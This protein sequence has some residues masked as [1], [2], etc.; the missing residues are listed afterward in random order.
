[1]RQ[2]LAA[3]ARS[4]GLISTWRSFPASAKVAG[5][6][7]GPT[8]GAVPKAGGAPG[9]G[10]WDGG[11]WGVWAGRMAVSRTDEPSKPRELRE[12]IERNVRRDVGMMVLIQSGEWIGTI[13]IWLE[14][15]KGEI[16]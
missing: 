14:A 10:D 3:V 2:L 8:G 12:V 13:L 9:V 1:M 7:S 15:G 16:A 4:A 5:V 6:T 11:A